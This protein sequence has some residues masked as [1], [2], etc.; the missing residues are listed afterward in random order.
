MR[1]SKSV[2]LLLVAIGLLGTWAYHLYEK[3]DYSNQTIIIYVKDSTDVLQA[4][5]DSLRGVFAATLSD[6]PESLDSLR[7]NLKS[8]SDNQVNDL[9]K[10]NALNNEI[11][12][13]CTLNH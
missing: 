1:K 13:F 9:D 11:I 7:Y 2:L 4:T 10:I 6:L 12:R 8:K 3:N 5:R